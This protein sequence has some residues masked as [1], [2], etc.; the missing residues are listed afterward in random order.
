MD[1][2]DAYIRVH[3]ALRDAYTAANEKDYQNAEVFALKLVEAA[4]ELLADIQNKK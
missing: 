4:Q 1:Y 3:H 2:S